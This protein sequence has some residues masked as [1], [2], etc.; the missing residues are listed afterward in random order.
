MTSLS[1]P[2]ILLLSVSLHACT[3]R[4]PSLS[5]KD[6]LHKELDKVKLLE[7]LTTSSSLKDYTLQ[8]NQ[9]QQQKPIVEAAAS[10]TSFQMDSPSF[11]AAED[12]RG[13]ARSMLGTVQHHHVEETVFTKASDSA[14]DIVEMDYAQPHRKPPIHNE[15]P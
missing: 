4:F 9:Q 13:P 11:L 8:K 3:A 12:E 14:E 6:T 2:I 10:G 1:L 15:K 7:T 5:K